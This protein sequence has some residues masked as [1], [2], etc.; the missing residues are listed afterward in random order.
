V[1][2]DRDRRRR[3]DT[4]AFRLA[5]PEGTRLFEIDLA[6]IL[7]FKEGVLR[8]DPRAARGRP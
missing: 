7:R 3:L 6:P 8:S 4:R 2:S 1:P 5:W